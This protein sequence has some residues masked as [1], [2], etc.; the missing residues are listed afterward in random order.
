MRVEFAQKQRIIILF[1]PWCEKDAVFLANDDERKEY[2]LED[3]G[4]IWRGSYKNFHAKKWNFGQFDFD[5]RD[6]IFQLLEEN[7]KAED[8]WNPIKVSDPI[9]VW[10]KLQNTSSGKIWE[11]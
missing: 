1:N 9:S 10:K 8:R 3:T 2:L 7:V 4:L 6:V 11:P 5:V